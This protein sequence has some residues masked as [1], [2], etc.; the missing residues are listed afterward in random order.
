MVKVLENSIVDLDVVP[1]K[2]EQQLK[3][4]ARQQAQAMSGQA[5]YR[6]PRAAGYDSPSPHCT[7]ILGSAGQWLTCLRL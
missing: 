4:Q 2:D 7:S 5:G 6:F 1:G 3:A